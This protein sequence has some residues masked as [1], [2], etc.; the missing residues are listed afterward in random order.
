MA[1]GLAHF[2]ELPHKI[3]L[4]DQEYL[5]VQQ[6]YRGWAWLGIVIF[7]SLIS[8]FWLT[9]KLRDNKKAFL[10]AL[11]AFFSIVGAQIIFWVFTFPVNQQTKNWTI[12]PPGWQQLRS[13]WEYSYAAGAIL[14]II[15]LITL[16]LAALNTKIMSGDKSL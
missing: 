15:A 3:H 12:L 14:D 13:R 11:T 9:I 16:I 6:I 4:T 8:N 1:G 2:L 7:A 10:L 5:T